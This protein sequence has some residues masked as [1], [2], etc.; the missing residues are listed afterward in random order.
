MSALVP[1]KRI[2]IAID[3]AARAALKARQGVEYLANAEVRV[4]DDQGREVPK[5]GATMGEISKLTCPAATAFTEPVLS[6]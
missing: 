3:A 2:D 6:L 1:Y 4:V 5:D